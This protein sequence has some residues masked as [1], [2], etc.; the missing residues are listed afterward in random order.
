LKYSYTKEKEWGD[1]IFKK[2]NID[3]EKGDA[4]LLQVQKF[5]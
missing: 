4:E 3:T 5:D 2:E 1:A